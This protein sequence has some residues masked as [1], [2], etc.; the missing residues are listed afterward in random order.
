MEYIPP[1]HTILKPVISIDLF[2]E[3]KELKIILYETAI[4][5]YKGHK[6]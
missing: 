4:L 3:K 1:F 6:N 2:K 5:G